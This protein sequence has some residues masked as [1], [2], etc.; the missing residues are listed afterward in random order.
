VRVLLDSIIDEDIQMAARLDRAAN[1]IL[2]GRLVTDVGLHQNS[3]ATLVR[4]RQ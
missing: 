4:S 1:G 3:P 2:T